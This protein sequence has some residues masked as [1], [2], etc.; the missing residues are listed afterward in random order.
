MGAGGTGEKGE[1]VTSI[2]KGKEEN[3]PFKLVGGLKGLK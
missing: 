3:T 1:K 2:I